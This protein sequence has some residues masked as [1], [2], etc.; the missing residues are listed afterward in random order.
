MSLL[1]GVFAIW[2]WGVKAVLVCVARTRHLMATTMS[3]LAE[4]ALEAELLHTCIGFITCEFE[5]IE[6]AR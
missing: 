5:L 1:V 3:I 6:L 2:G 4:N